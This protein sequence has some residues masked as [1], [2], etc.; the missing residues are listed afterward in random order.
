L[1]TAANFVPA[2]KTRALATGVAVA[3]SRTCPSIVPVST[4]MVFG[5]RIAA[6]SSRSRTGSSDIGPSR[7]EIP[8]RDD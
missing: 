3:A 7:G 5:V 6:R 2:I 4:A 1:V 8:R